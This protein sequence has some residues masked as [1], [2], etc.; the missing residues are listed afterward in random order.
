LTATG[1]VSGTFAS[2]VDTN[3]PANF[4]SSLSCDAKAAE[5]AAIERQ[6]KLFEKYGYMDLV[7]I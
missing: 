4:T 1:G 3:L 7:P 6:A 5:V 2:L